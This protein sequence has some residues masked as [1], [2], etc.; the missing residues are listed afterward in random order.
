MNNYSSHYRSL[1]PLHPSSYWIVSPSHFRLPQFHRLYHYHWCQPQHVIWQIQ[2]PPFGGVWLSSARQP[3]VHQGERIM[4]L[5]F[6][7]GLPLSYVFVLRLACGSPL[8]C[9]TS[10]ASS[11]PFAWSPWLPLGGNLKVDFERG[12]AARA[13]WPGPLAWRR[14]RPISWRAEP[15]Y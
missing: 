10:Q 8:S 14:A 12:R 3:P 4:Q 11:P 5:G 2:R 9:V 1:H 6:L 13:H 7:K 15:C